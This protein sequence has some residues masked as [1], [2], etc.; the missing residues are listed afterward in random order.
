MIKIINHTAASHWDGGEIY[1]SDDATT[2]VADTSDY[3]TTSIE[4]NDGR[5]MVIIVLDDR[6]NGVSSDGVNTDTDTVADNVRNAY[7]SA[8]GL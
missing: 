5:V 2:I 7:N 6:G 8:K 4:L 3:E 1:N